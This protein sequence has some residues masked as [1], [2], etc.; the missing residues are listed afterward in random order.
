M[1]DAFL[2]SLKCKSFIKLIMEEKGK[3]RFVSDR[4]SFIYRN[5][6]MK[7]KVGGKILEI[8]RATTFP[9]K[10]FPTVSICASIQ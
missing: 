4:K 10:T 5:R 7:E 3:L 6:P 2:N 8:F 1:D 9:T